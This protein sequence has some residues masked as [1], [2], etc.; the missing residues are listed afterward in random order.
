MWWQ[1]LPAGRIFIP[2]RLLKYTGICLDGPAGKFIDTDDFITIISVMHE[3]TIGRV[4]GEYKEFGI[5]ASLVFL[6][7]TPDRKVLNDVVLSCDDNWLTNAGAY[8]HI[9]A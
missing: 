4:H 9:I 8:F 5:G 1:Q 6:N 3:P 2:G 7:T